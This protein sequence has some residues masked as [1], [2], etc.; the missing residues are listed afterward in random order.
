MFQV[1]ILRQVLW[2]RG[3]AWN[4]TLLIFW[5]WLFDPWYQ[6]VVPYMHCKKPTGEI[7]F[8]TA[9]SE[10]CRCMQRKSVSSYPKRDHKHNGIW[11][12]SK[13]VLEC[14][15]T[16]RYLWVLTSVWKERFDW[17]NGSLYC[18]WKLERLSN[19]CRKADTK[20]ISTANRNTSKQR[21]QPI[22]IPTN[23]L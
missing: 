15:G 4:T 9:V 3:N 11:E 2:R 23:Y 7:D 21:H 8:K 6:V 18:S 16:C 10:N 17:Y 1:K 5:P 19:D 12:F 14:F 20:A 13:E 22:T